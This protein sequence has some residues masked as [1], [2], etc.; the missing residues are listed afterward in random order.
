MVQIRTE[1]KKKV[2][3]S[4][5]TKIIGQPTNQG[6]DLLKE[7]LPAIAALITT[8]L[9][10]GNNGHAGILMD[11]GEYMATFGVA[12]VFVAPANPGVCPAGPF[13]AAS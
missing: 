1:I 3:A 2:A 5:V 7:E 10:G 12:T 8:P 9:G 13:P 4:V 6:I 11:D